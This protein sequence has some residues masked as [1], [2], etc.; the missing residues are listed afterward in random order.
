M[1][2]IAGEILADPV[3]DTYK[4]TG[5]IHHRKEGKTS[6]V[7]IAYLPGVMDPV[8]LT[9][10]SLLKK[11]GI[12]SVT[13]VRTRNRYEIAGKL[14]NSEI[15]FLVKKLLMN[16][17]IQKWQKNEKEIHT[18]SLS[19]RMEKTVVPI[20]SCSE[21]ELLAISRDGLLSLNA[22]EMK[23]IQDYFM[24]MGRDP[25][26]IELET[27]AQTW[28]EHC[29][30]KTFRG[31]IVYNGTVIRD[32]LASTIAK[33]TK[34]LKKRFCISVFKDNAGIIKFN[35][36]YGITF[37]VETHNH[38][39]AL[40]PYGGAGTGIGGVIRDTMGTGLGAKPIANTDI[41]CFGNLSFSMKHLPETVLHPKRIFKGV[42]AGVRDYGNRM[43]IPTINGAILFDNAYLYNPVVYCGSIGIIPIEYS[44]K[45][46]KPNDL[47]IVCGGKTGKDGIH[48][49]TFASQELD[50]SSEASSSG[51]VQIGNPITEKKLLDALLEAR[52]E[53]LYNAITD[54]GGGGLSSAV[55]E[56]GKDLGATVHLEK[57]P[58]K[59]QGL[60]YDEIWISESQERMIVSVP[61]RHVKQIGAI[62]KKHD[63]DFAVIG[64]FEQTGKLRLYFGS[65]KVGELAMD[66]LHDGYPQPNKKATWR[67]KRFAEPKL[68]RA[69]QI[70]TT[71][72]KLLSH[73]NIASKEVVVRQ[74]DHEVQAMSALKPMIGKANDGPSDGAILRP[75]ANSRRGVVVANGINPYYG[76]IDPYWMAASVIEEALR[77]AIACG[78]DPQKAALLDNFS[79]GDVNNPRILGQLVRAS[80]GC[81]DTAIALGAPFISGKDSLNNTF[82]L[83]GKKRSILSTLLIS[84]ISICD[85]VTKSASSDLKEEG[86]PLYMIGV[87]KRELGGSH[88]YKLFNRIGNRVPK[89]DFSVSAETLKNVHRA[90]SQGSV[91]AIHDCSEGGIGVTLAEMTIGGGRGAEINIS[92]I[93]TSGTLRADELLFSESNSRF[94]AEICHTKEAAFK[95]AM[96][97]V[98]HAR[99]G[100][101]NASGKLTIRKGKKLVSMIEIGRMARRWKKRIR[102]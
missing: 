46:P 3:A 38:P 98:P 64:K 5:H 28:S 89:L 2:R 78:G 16:S 39:S 82:S 20:I 71:L 40:E 49:V 45:E 6:F 47:I 96:G 12:G 13:E 100:S 76:K 94:I 58:L 60:R 86:D 63:V 18:Q 83:N 62:F 67:S 54:C 31:H 55:G 61:A 53:K 90:I 23:E 95:K 26:D 27:I 30:H 93:P 25:S 48:G 34:E 22:A 57:V 74:Y 56:M 87:T 85:D 91:A 88:F 68:P 81:R 75:F 72:L 84:C 4:L 1:E 43:G 99:I 7:E 19:S 42:I 17:L 9:T 80:L 14:T 97:S 10:H 77:N 21:D 44:F 51:A 35:S 59:Y 8:A 24:R 73:P 52:D 32:L 29:V 36:R 101:V 69:P 37:K 11:I 102:W 15:S 92:S 41:F 50:E 33:A 65:K 70:E 66:F 79:W